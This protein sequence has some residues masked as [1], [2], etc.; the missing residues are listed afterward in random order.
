MELSTAFNSNPELFGKFFRFCGMIVSTTFSSIFSRVLLF[1]NIKCVSPIFSSS[2]TALY[3]Q[4][5]FFASNYLIILHAF[6]L[7]KPHC[8]AIV[9]MFSFE[10]IL[11][12]VSTFFHPVLSDHGYFS[13]LFTFIRSAA[14]QFSLF[15]FFRISYLQDNYYLLLNCYLGKITQIY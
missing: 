15:N 6:C 1:I 9:S 12:S 14:K 4:I 3:P 11:S 7:E 5:S 2:I 10:F 8:F 13:T